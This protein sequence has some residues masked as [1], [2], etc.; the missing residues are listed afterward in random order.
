MALAS[1]MLHVANEEYKQAV[2]ERASLA[3]VQIAA[4]DSQ[5]YIDENVKESRQWLRNT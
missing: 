5:L 2:G 4:V 1:M 3:Q